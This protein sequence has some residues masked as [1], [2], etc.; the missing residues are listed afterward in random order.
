MGRFV[1]YQPCQLGNCQLLNCQLGSCQLGSCQLLNCQL[2]H[3]QLGNCQLGNCQ[4]WQL[5]TTIW[6]ILPGGM[7]SI[8][9]KVFARMHSLECIPRK[10]FAM[11]GVSLYI[12]PA[13]GDRSDPR[14][15]SPRKMSPPKKIPPITKYNM[16]SKEDVFYVEDLKGLL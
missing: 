12:V 14:K 1:G 11:G 10:L 16:F 2:G 13:H 3:C 5:P 9:Q 15:I 7:E 4:L 8:P 6:G